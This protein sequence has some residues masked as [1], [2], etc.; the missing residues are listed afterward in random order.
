MRKGMEESLCEER[1]MGE[2]IEKKKQIEGMKENEKGNKKYMEMEKREREMVREIMGYEMKNRGRIER[3]I[4]KRIE[5]KLKENEV[6][7]KNMINV[8]VEK[9]LYIEMKE[10][11]E[12]DIEVEEEKRDKRKRKYEGMV[13]E[14]MRSIERKKE[15]EIENKFE[16]EENVKEWFEKRIKEEYGKEKEEKIIEMKEYEK[17]IDLKVK[18]DEKEWEEKIGGVEIKNGQVRMKKVEG[19]IKEMKGFEEGEWWVKD[20]EERMNERMMEDIK[21][22]RVEDICEEKGGKKEKIVIKGEEVKEIEM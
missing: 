21:G 2:V 5:R 20:V 17:K 4:K 7:M 13:K 16:K 19:N 6:E 3:E 22:K 10:N 14:M 18:G 15:R 1:I 11:Q 9:I 8:E 12:V